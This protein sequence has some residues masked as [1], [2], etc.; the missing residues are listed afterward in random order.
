MH[1]E[2][3]GVE[4]YLIVFFVGIA[5]L[6][7]V[8]VRITTVFQI[9]LTPQRDYRRNRKTDCCILLGLYLEKRKK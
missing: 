9:I 6:M 3:I 2:D 4:G 5:V 8:I 1:A 7:Y